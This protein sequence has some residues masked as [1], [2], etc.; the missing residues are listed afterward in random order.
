MPGDSV[1]EIEA[2]TVPIGSSKGT[3]KMDMYLSLY[4]NAPPYTQY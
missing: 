1:T 4:K 3:D 2:V